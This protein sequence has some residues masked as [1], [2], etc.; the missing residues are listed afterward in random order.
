MATEQSYPIDQAELVEMLSGAGKSLLPG[1]LG[2][3]LIE[4]TAGGAVMRCDI[5]QQHFAPNGYLHG[6]LI[7]S[8][9]DTV[10]GYGCIG[11]LPKGGI[12]FTTIEAKANFVGAIREGAIMAT[13][14][15][16]HGG[17]TTQVW[18]VEVADELD[19]KT[20]AAFRCTQMIL[21]PR[22]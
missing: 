9:A 13:G 22:S 17:R 7:M 12:G 11:N 8:I 16:I 1:L 19:G 18:D 6:G 3:E 20:L 14:T 15:M 2:L 21:Y 10:A 5:R 4:I